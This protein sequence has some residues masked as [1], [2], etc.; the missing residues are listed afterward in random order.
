MLTAIRL[1][2]MVVKDSL[3]AD[4]RAGVLSIHFKGEGRDVDVW[5]R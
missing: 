1:G 2:S 4:Q 3:R 5:K